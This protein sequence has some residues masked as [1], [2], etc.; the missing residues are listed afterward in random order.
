MHKDE[1]HYI[2]Q[3]IT[4]YVEAKKLADEYAELAG[5]LKDYLNSKMIDNDLSQYENGRVNMKRVTVKRT[6]ALNLDLMRDDG[7]D[8]SRYYKTPETVSCHLRI[9]IKKDSK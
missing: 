8:P 4:E 9:Q 2:E 3:L 6:P 7:I 1:E 5:N